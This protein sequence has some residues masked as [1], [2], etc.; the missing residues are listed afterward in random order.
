[1]M[2]YITI[3]FAHVQEP[4]T[5]IWRKKIGWSKFERADKRFSDSRLYEKCKIIHSVRVEHWFAKAIELSFNDMMVGKRWKE[6]NIPTW[7]MGKTEVLKPEV[8]DKE[9]IDR[10]NSVV[11]MKQP[12]LEDWL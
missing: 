11:V 10:F 8:T 7:F 1:M 9:V 6:Y 4:E 2:E 5:K 12:T 3:Y